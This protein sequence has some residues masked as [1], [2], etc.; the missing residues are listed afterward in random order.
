MPF[1]LDQSLWYTLE[2]IAFMEQAV[3]M[4]ISVLMR[5]KDE[6]ITDVS[7][8]A[9]AHALQ[10]ERELSPDR[11]AVTRKFFVIIQGVEIHA[12]SPRAITGD[13]QV[14]EGSLWI[15]REGHKP[16]AYAFVRLLTSTYGPLSTPGTQTRVALPAPVLAVQN[17]RDLA[18]ARDAF[19]FPMRDDPG[20][21][22]QVP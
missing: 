12:G 1:S 9:L 19:E 8:S 3:H 20:P 6:H 2:N 18:D 13:F 5:L 21:D 11:V 14:V 22:F 16:C 10:H 15:E 17:E 4:R 7:I